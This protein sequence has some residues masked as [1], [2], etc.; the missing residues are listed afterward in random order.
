[1][2][3]AICNNAQAQSL[4]PGQSLVGYQCYHIDAQALKLTSDDAWSGK[5]FPPVFTEPSE[6]SDRLGVASGIVYVAWPL[7]Q[8][9]GFVKTVRIGG[10]LGWISAD[11]VRPLYR[12]PGSKGGCTLL[13]RG[14]RIQFHLDPG[15]K[16]WLFPNG[17][18]I[19]D[20]KI[21]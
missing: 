5:G 15:A 3:G 2:L 21:R 10:E 8:E 13:W 1:M 19:P 20:D 12:E 9:N 11:V 17:H 14:N 4:A 7:Q 6:A 18:D 16:A